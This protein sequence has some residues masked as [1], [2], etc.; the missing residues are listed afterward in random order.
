MD[1]TEYHGGIDEL[2]DKPRS[3]RPALLNAK[4]QKQ[5]AR[6]ASRPASDAI[7]LALCHRS[8]LL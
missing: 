1:V 6:G 5:L 3:G 7:R 8:R 4:Q 2:L